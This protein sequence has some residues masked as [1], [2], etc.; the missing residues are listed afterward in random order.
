MSD[1]V[2]VHNSTKKVVR[3]QL[4]NTNIVVPLNPDDDIKVKVESRD[5]YNYYVDTY[6]AKDADTVKA[7]T[8]EKKVEENIPHGQDT[9]VSV[10]DISEEHIESTDNSDEVVS[11]TDTEEL[12]TSNSDDN[13]TEEV[14][15]KRRRG[16][17]PKTGQEMTDNGN[18]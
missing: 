14:V 17:R 4:Y 13:N 6:G 2:V 10:A 12:T 9:E 5:A 11:E 7:V 15:V 16:R 1:I 3:V 8:E 18:S